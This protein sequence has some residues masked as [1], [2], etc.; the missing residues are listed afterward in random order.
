MNVESWRFLGFVS[1]LVVHFR[2]AGRS[3]VDLDLDALFSQLALASL[4]S[5]RVESSLDY[6]VC[7]EWNE[8]TNMTW[9]IM[10]N[11]CDKM[12]HKRWTGGAP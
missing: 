9:M 2:T 11:A 7:M 5:L 8:K 4:S 1:A 6:P 3:R 12:K 10:A